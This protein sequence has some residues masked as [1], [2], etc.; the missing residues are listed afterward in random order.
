MKFIF[1]LLFTLLLT[2][3]ATDKEKIPFTD[4]PSAHP[5]NINTV[6]RPPEPKKLEK[7]D[8]LKIRALVFDYLLSRHFWDDGEYTAIFL[9]GKED[10]VNELIKKL[11]NHVPPVKASYHADLPPNHTPIDKDTGKPA[12]IL[13]VDVG[14]PNADDS[15]DAIGRWYAGGAVAGFYTFELKKSGDGWEIGS[16]K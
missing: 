3:C 9:Q 11:P 4:E 10:E 7:A 12:M 5:V 8:E 6:A 15:V 16:V 13:S 14:E 1:P 2:G